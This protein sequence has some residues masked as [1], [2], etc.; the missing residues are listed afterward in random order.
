MPVTAELPPFPSHAGFEELRDN[1]EIGKREATDRKF[2][3]KLEEQ[4]VIWL[5]RKR[6]YGEGEGMPAPRL[7][8]VDKV[9]LRALRGAEIEADDIAALIDWFD[10]AI[11]AV[12]AGG[13]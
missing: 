9:E 12:K 2:V 6:W 8:G 1:I 13:V 11:K 3:A 5:K 7:S 4:R 10:A